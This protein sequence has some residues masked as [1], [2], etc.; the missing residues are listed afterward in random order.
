M[1]II[2]KKANDRIQQF[3]NRLKPLGLYAEVNEAEFYNK[4]LYDTWF[5]I[6]NWSSLTAIDFKKPAEE[7]ENYLQRRVAS[8]NDYNTFGFFLT[9]HSVDILDV[10]E[11]QNRIVLLGDAGVGKTTE[12]LRI[13]SHFSKPN[14]PLTPSFLSLN[15][16]VNENLADLLGNNWLTYSQNRTIVILH[17]L[18]EIEAKNKND[19]IRKIELF[20]EQYPACTIIIS[21]RRNFYNQEKIDES[22]TLRFFSYV[23]L[24]L[25]YKDVEKYIQKR[26]GNKKEIFCDQVENNRLGGLLRVPFYLVSLVKLFETNNNKL[27]ESKAEIFEYLLNDRLKF[28]SK[29]FRTTIELDINREKIHGI[30]T[31]CYDYDNAR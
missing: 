25:D 4:V 1:F 14:S 10:I 16:Y 26:L 28:D 27:P 31:Y 20:A 7:N 29:H 9:H 11:K 30:R 15:K 18:D 3:K 17:G 8:T 2:R 21:C 13:K 19:A 12:L 22:G 5:K 6:E 23:L 24:E